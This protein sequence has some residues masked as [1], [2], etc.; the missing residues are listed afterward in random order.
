TCAPARLSDFLLRRCLRSDRWLRRIAGM[1][2]THRGSVRLR[3]AAGRSFLREGLGS[4]AAAEAR[5]APATVD[6]ARQRLSRWAWPGLMALGRAGACRTEKR[7]EAAA[8][9]APA[10]ADTIGGL[11]RIQPGNG[12]VSIG[13]RSLSGQASIVKQLLVAEGD[14]VHAGQALAELDSRDQLTALEQH[15]RARVE[16]A[17]RRLAQVQSGAKPSELAA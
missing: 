4:R 14:T 6:V 11:G 13:A 17:R 10:A 8:A 7:P 15:A 16:V 9:Q 5:R 1:A 2:R 3:D 12:I